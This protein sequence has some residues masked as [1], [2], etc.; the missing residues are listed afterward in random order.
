MQMCDLHIKPHSYAMFCSLLQIALYRNLLSKKHSDLVSMME[1]LEEGVQKL[2]ST[3]AQA[4]TYLG[5]A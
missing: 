4:C 2:K 1:R 5:Y 3:A